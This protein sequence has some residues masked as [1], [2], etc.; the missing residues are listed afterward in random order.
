MDYFI[1]YG[2]PITFIGVQIS[3][4][5][6]GYKIYQ[7]RNVGNLSI[8]PFFTLFINCVVWGIYG[9]LINAFPV[10]GYNNIIILTLIYL[11]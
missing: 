4:L 11:F 10:Y 3:S 1:I 2:G 8:I 7:E 6:T 5:L 9:F